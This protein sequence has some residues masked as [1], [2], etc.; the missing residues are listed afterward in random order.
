MN[1]LDNIL[2][3]VELPTDKEISKETQKAAVAKSNREK[4]FNAKTMANIRAANLKKAKDP[5]WRKKVQYANNNWTEERR[6]AYMNRDKSYLKEGSSY[7]VGLT[8]RNHLSR[9]PV[10]VKK[11]GGEWISY[12]SIHAFAQTTNDPK[13][14]TSGPQYYFPKYM[15]IKTIKHNGSAYVGWQFRRL[16]KEQAKNRKL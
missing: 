7:R 8:K 6:A 13:M 14:F 11:P 5:E 12:E 16:V 10:E 2:L 4:R 15:S 3:G 9:I 1:D